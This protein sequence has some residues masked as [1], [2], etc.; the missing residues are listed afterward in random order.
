[1]MVRFSCFSTP[2]NRSKKVVQHSVENLLA[3]CRCVTEDQSIKLSTGSIESN[4]MF[5]STSCCNT[6]DQNISPCF[7]KDCWQ[8]EDLNAKHTEDNDVVNRTVQIKKSYS[9]GNMMEKTSGFSGDDVMGGVDVDHDFSPEYLNDWNMKEVRESFGNTDSFEFIR[10]E[11]DVN[12]NHDKQKEY[13]LLNGSIRN[14]SLFSVEILKHS[15]K[16][17]H[18]DIAAQTADHIVISGCSSKQL[19]TLLRSC[20]VTNLKVNVAE[21]SED[22]LGHRLAFYRSRSFSGLN[23]LSRLGADFQNLGRSFDS[24]IHIEKSI[25]VSPYVKPTSDGGTKSQCSFHANEEELSLV[26]SDMVRNHYSN[27][28]LRKLEAK[29]AEIKQSSDV[30][31]SYYDWDQLTLEEFSMKR[32]E[33]WISQIDIRGD[34]TVEETGEASAS[35]SKENPEIRLDPRKPDAKSFQAMEVPHNCMSSLSSTSS[36]AHMAN[37]GLVT[38]PTLTPFVSLRCLN[39]SGNSIVRVAPGSLPKGLHMLNLSKNNISS[40][41]GLRDLSHLRVLDL[42]YNRIAKIGHGLSSCTSLKELYIAGNKISEIEGL[43]RLAK[44]SIID[45]RFNKIST[46]KG[47][48]QLAANYSSIKVIN[49]E[50][51]PAL[52]NVGDEQL[53]KFLLGLLPNLVCYNK[54]TIRKGSKEVSGR[55]NFAAASSHFDRV[56]RA[57]H[58]L[59]KKASIGSGPHKLAASHGRQSSA[60]GMLMKLTKDR[61][62]PAASKLNNRGSGKKLLSEA[63]RRSQSTDAL[64]SYFKS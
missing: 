45:L 55:S 60:E 48:G 11:N 22:S 28:E 51:N 38:V 26:R 14:E 64:R 25:L 35:D 13:D 2:V 4:P 33:H 44:L 41:E 54:Q 31:T 34:F 59:P 15:D 39:L 46:A 61:L 16:D 12:N 63:M 50:G 52:I 18:A 21:S 7:K 1:M 23:N 8:A 20:S 27:D 36:S 3:D 6:A 47:L 24:S 5:D 43:H 53:K 32:V 56:I 62:P 40:I 57:E 19:C 49:I 10:H 30:E 42:S 37:L 58:K 17:Q 9:L 29:D